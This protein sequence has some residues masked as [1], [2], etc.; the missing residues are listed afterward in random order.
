MVTTSKLN[1]LTWKIETHPDATH[2]EFDGEIDENVDFSELAKILNNDVVFNLGGIRKINSCGVREWVN[3]V[4]NLPGITS[5]VYS[6][7][8]PTVVT[9]LNL[10]T[11]FRGG[12]SLRS[13]YAPYMCDKCEYETEKLFVVKDDFPNKCHTDLPSFTCSDCNIDLEFDDMPE[14][15]LAFLSEE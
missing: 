1:R 3:F 14:R 4:R 12:A 9:Q 15:Y 11:N 10:I 13:F 7:C 6:H 5:L 8:S 2:V